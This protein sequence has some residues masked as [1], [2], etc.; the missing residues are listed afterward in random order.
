MVENRIPEDRRP[1]Y[2][3]I[4]PDLAFSYLLSDSCQVMGG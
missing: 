4:L 1:V 2:T 3:C